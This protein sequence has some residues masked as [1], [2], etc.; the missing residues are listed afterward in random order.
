MTAIQKP[1]SPSESEKLKT[2][3][4]NEQSP[5]LRPEVM[6]AARRGMARYEEALK[7]LAK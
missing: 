7:L 4:E 2:V 5:K 3:N 6:E 1:K